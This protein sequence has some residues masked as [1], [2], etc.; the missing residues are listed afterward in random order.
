[1][2]RRGLDHRAKRVIIRTWAELSGAL[3]AKVTLFCGVTSAHNST[4]KE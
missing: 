4:T 3:P 2:M 1:M